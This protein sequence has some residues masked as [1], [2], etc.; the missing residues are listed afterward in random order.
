MFYSLYIKFIYFSFQLVEIGKSFQLHI[1]CIIDY[2]RKK[3]FSSQELNQKT[4]NILPPK[5]QIW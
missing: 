5:A 2:K 4:L 3:R 1:D